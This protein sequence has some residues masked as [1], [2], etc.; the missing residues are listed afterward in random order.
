MKLVM[1]N[2]NYSSWSIRPWFFMKH[3]GIAFEEIVLPMDQPVFYE[4][5]VKWS[6]S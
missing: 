6:P 5:I 2:K 4:E 3:A 1:G